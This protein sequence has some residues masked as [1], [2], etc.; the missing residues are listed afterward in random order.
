MIRSLSFL[1][2]IGGW[3]LAD[4]G[5]AHAVV[6]FSV[7]RKGQVGTESQWPEGLETALKK[8]P[9]V[10]GELTQSFSFFDGLYDVSLYYRGVQRN[11]QELID[12]LGKMEHVTVRVTID[13][14]GDVGKVVHR[15][16]F[17][18][19]R[20]ISYLYRVDVH[21]SGTMSQL[22]TVEFHKR[23]MINVI[24]YSAGGLEPDRLL[25]PDTINKRKRPLI[26]PAAG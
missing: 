5:N 21:R 9:P 14:S 10:R 3:L 1:C 13:R 17:P 4:V 6:S 26:G 7:L 18:V 12:A 19:D 24:V 22:K 16:M 11:V 20:P 23:M 8:V 2:L 25:I 15:R